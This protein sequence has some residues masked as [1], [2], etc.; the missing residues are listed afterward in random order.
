VAQAAVLSTADRLSPLPLAFCFGSC[1]G[2]FGC[3]PQP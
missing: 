2:Q 3:F 1:G